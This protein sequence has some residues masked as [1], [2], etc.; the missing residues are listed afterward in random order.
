MTSVIVSVLGIRLRPLFILR[1]LRWSSFPIASAPALEANTPSTS[2]PRERVVKSM[3]TLTVS[4]SG[5]HCGHVFAVAQIPE[6][7]DTVIA[8]VAVD[9]VDLS[10]V[11]VAEKRSC[12]QPVHVPLSATTKRNLAI[13]VPAILGLC[14]SSPLWPIHVAR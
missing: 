6:I 2:R 3:T 5:L 9:V 1:A 12:Y 4:D 8:H 11:C 13:S 10:T 7:A 14:Q